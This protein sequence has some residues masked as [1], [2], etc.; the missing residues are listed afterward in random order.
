M[1]C[2][3]YALFEF[4]D[5]RGQFLSDMIASFFNLLSNG[6]QEVRTT[7]GEAETP[8]D[9]NLKDEERQRLPEMF[10]SV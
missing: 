5:R 4:S 6:N 2:W 3:L 9:I 1:I 7:L 8:I 10:H